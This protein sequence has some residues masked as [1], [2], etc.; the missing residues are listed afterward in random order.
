MLRKINELRGQKGSMMVEAIAMLGLISM[1]TPVIY[2][3]AAERTNEMQDINAASQVR[4]LVNAIDDYLRDNY[5]TI[6]SGG[7]VSSNSAASDQD[8]NYGDYDFGANDASTTP[9]T[10][11]SINIEHFRD[12]LPLGFKAQG[13]IFNDFDVVIKQTRDPSGERKALTTI[14][15]A[16]PNENNPDLSR[17]RSSRIASMIGTNGGF[18][19]GEKATG[20][21]G[22]WE[23]EKDE[24]PN[25]DSIKDGSI[26]ATS[27]E[28][29]ADGTGGGK[30]VLHRVYVPGREEY[31]RMETTLYMGGED[32]AEVSN[33]I[34][35]SHDNTVNVK[36][37]TGDDTAILH[38]DGEGLVDSTLKA[39]GE[40]FIAD[41]GYMQH[42][43]SL[44]VGAGNTEAASKFAVMGDE[45]SVR[46]LDGKFNV[47]INASK[48]YIKLTG[49]NNGTVLNANEGLVSFMDQNVTISPAGNTDI[50]GYAHVDGDLG[51]GAA[52][53]GTYAVTANNTTSD[54]YSS[55]LKVTQSPRQVT[56]GT[57]A[58][59]ADLRVYGAATID[60][61]TVEKNFKAGKIGATSTYGLTVAETTGDVTTNAKVISKNAAGTKIF[62]VGDTLAN[63]T[64]AK[65]F[66]AGSYNNTRGGI[67]LAADETGAT[68]RFKDNSSS[69]LVKDSSDNN[70]IQAT[71]GSTSIASGGSTIA[72]FYT[73][74]ANQTQAKFTADLSVY[75]GTSNILTV[76]NDTSSATYGGSS[77]DNGRG[78]VHIR[79]GAI[80]LDRN[81]S[82]NNN[83][84]NPISYVKA[85]RFVA[86]V[87]GSADADKTNSLKGSGTYSFEVNP[88]YTSMM[89]DIK[90]ASRGGAR[91]SDIL[92][93]F[94]NKGIYVLDNTYSGNKDWT[95]SSLSWNGLVLSGLT[96]CGAT[97]NCDT[98]PWLGFIPTPNC[99]PGY[100]Q[101]AT[102]TPIRFAMAQAG[103]PIAT[104][105]ATP[106]F[107]DVQ[108]RSDPRG[109]DL[110]IGYAADAASTYNKISTPL[111]VVRDN[112]P[113]NSAGGLNYAIGGTKQSKPPYW[114]E[115]MNTP[116]TFQVNTWLNTTLK[117]YYH[118]SKFQG[119][120]GIMGFIYP[121]QTY[122][123]Y[124]K[125]I[126]AIA[127]GTTVNSNMIIWN[128]FPVRKEELSAIATIYCYFDRGNFSSTYVDQY[129]PHATTTMGNIRYQE[130]GTTPTY[131]DPNLNYTG[132]W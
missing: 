67:G 105:P 100:A 80:E 11:D 68:I 26:V 77:I 54:F 94:I 51:V 3:K 71:Q 115:M 13:K 4:T 125:A 81:S 23:I 91:L 121:A 37:A 7:T 72:Q 18:Y 93:D 32:L 73:T 102:I 9:K 76:S 97:A 90:L 123:A 65:S 5:V 55:T 16:K 101:V 70:Q 85:D 104:K 66:I 21:Q 20:V 39:A 131:N 61:L 127:S 34:A 50:G 36:G 24:L 96:D 29:V 1:V 84:S 110:S 17:I 15:V 113:S 88:A 120:H 116:Y 6:T 92:P 83:K 38:V 106:D 89:N 8:V 14:L 42:T 10:T 129:L 57:S 19:D 64:V 40:N 58:N 111:V 128:L 27:I 119:W 63:T 117:A 53:N 114:A 22:V 132:V 82:A 60:D 130:K 126:G 30:N 45:G 74:T 122:E 103:I 52:T 112:D 25:S 86:N 69:F 28:A 33:L 78:S 124:A 87:T 2:K 48:P 118:G 12:Y 107:R 109:D 79:K 46:A 95:A 62:D 49:S 108:F 98:S 59:S 99:P 75:D 41:T 56:I 44:Y 35:L 47:D 43:T 31:N